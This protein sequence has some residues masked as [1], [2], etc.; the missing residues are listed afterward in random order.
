L[1]RV[2]LASWREAI[3]TEKSFQFH[4]VRKGNLV[5]AVATPHPVRLGIRTGFHHLCSSTD[6]QSLPD[7]KT[8]VLQVVDTHNLLDVCVIAP[9]YQPE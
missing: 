4:I 5:R 6:N 3:N 1:P 2:Y 7:V 9:G 8:S